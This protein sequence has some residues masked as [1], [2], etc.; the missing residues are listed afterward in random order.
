M[1]SF[2]IM[3]GPWSNPAPFMKRNISGNVHCPSVIAKHLVEVALKGKM[4]MP[5]AMVLQVRATI[6]FVLNWASRR[7]LQKLQV[8]APWRE[9][10]IKSRE[11]AIDFASAHNIGSGHEEKRL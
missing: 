8:I 1:N 10:N 11:D 3:L 9:W 7:W 6:R 5:S 2:A 4:P